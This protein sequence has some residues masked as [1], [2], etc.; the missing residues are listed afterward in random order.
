MKIFPDDV[1]G[2]LCRAGDVAW[3]LFH[4]ER[5][6]RAEGEEGSWIITVLDIHFREV[7]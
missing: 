1:P 4:V 7:D 6:G 2:V 5:V 3:Q